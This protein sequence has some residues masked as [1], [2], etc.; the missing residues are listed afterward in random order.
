M[1]APGWI[2]TRNPSKLSAVD[3]RFRPLGY[4]DR[5]IGHYSSLP[6]PFLFKI[7]KATVRAA[8]S[9]VALSCKKLHRPFVTLDER[10]CV[11]N[12]GEFDGPVRQKHTFR[13]SDRSFEN[14]TVFMCVLIY[15]NVL[16]EEVKFR[17][18]LLPMVQNVPAVSCLKSS[19]SSPV[20]C[21]TTG[22]QPL[23]KRFLHLMRSRASSFKWQY[24][25]LSTRS[26]S[27]FL[28][29]LPRLLVTSI[30][31]CIFPSINC[32]KAVST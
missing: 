10:W 24:P 9:Y 25:L 22:P 15:S 23:P 2:R 3:P 20:I 14:A 6:N 5:H 21:H 27:S 13:T 32:F 18:C 26:S 11:N 4:W 8:P 29:L 19:S 1:H 28:R 17:E 12:D 7:R 31:P 30:R 16:L